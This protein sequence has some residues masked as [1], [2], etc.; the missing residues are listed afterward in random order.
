MKKKLALGIG[1]V[2]AGFLTLSLTVF[3]MGAAATLNPEA[4]GSPPAHA[5]EAAVVPADDLVPAPTDTPATLE[6]LGTG[7]AAAIEPVDSADP[8]ASDAFTAMTPDEQANGRE[9]LETQTITAT[10]MQEKGYAYT[11]EPF[12]G[13]DSAVIPVMWE[14]TLPSSE[15]AAARLALYGDTGGGADYH[16]DDA[17]CWGYAVHVMGNDNNH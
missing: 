9:W 1:L 8:T 4:P 13:R 5:A 2:G 16:W 11:F 10:C 6:A 14:D 17:G 3:G 15:R 7:E 12:W